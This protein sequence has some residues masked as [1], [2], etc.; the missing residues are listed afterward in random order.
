[1]G[2][3]RCGFVG[4]ATDDDARET[5]MMGTHIVRRRHEITAMALQR[6]RVR[7][8]HYS[9]QLLLCWHNIRCAILFVIAA[10]RPPKR[11]TSCW[12]ELHDDSSRSS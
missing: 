1:M 3:G 2:D 5:N 11:P 12:A 8:V 4:H 6:A 10:D 7:F 9:V